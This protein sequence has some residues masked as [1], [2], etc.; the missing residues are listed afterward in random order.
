MDHG[1]MGGCDRP[2]TDPLTHQEEI[3]AENRKAEREAGLLATECCACDSHVTHMPRR[4][5][6]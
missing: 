5:M 2:L 4:V 3:I 6:V 1:V